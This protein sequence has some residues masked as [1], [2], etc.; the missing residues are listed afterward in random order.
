MKLFKVKMI[1]GSDGGSEDVKE[2]ATQAELNAYLEGVADMDGWM[3]YDIEE[4]TE[5]S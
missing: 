5:R 2:F 1:W 3:E 4:I